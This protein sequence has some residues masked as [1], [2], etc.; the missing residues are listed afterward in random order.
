MSGFDLLH[1]NENE[2]RLDSSFI[3]EMNNDEDEEFL[4]NFNKDGDEAK[5]ESASYIGSGSA[6]LVLVL[7]GIVAV[8]LLSCFARTSYINYKLRQK[9]KK[10]VKESK[11]IQKSYRRDSSLWY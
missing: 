9:N 8:C 1:K 6:G 5:D 2:T 4:Y 3:P 7:G 10:S 11:I